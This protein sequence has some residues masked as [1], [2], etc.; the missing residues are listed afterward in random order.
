MGFLLSFRNELHKHIA[1]T[2]LVRSR[3]TQKP[4]EKTSWD[5]VLTSHEPVNPETGIG[6]KQRLSV[7]HS[8]RND[9]IEPHSNQK[10]DPD[11]SML[12]YGPPGTGK[13][14]IA[15]GL[16]MDWGDDLSRLP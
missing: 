2:T 10:S 6:Q 12:L 15:N 4:A 13:T 16:Q 1:R 14:T 5:N 3:F 8:I 11:F 7:Y 9:F